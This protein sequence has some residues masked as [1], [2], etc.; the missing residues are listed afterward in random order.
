MVSVL[1]SNRP[2]H[3]SFNTSTA[4]FLRTSNAEI[5]TRVNLFHT[6]DDDKPTAASIHTSNG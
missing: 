2:I 6:G 3:G 4:I 5:T 1:T